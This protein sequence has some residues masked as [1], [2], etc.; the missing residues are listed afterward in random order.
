[1]HLE[2]KRK[3]P[4]VHGY[5]CRISATCS[6]LKFETNDLTNSLQFPHE[7]GSQTPVLK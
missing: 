1:M 4:P 7:G 2:V 6:S 3:V 5:P